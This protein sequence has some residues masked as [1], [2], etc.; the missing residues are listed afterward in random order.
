MKYLAYVK[1]EGEFT[2]HV[3]PVMDENCN[4]V[5]FDSEEEAQTYIFN[6]YTEEYTFYYIVKAYKEVA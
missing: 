5:L 6:N 2:D 1:Y 3:C 4:H